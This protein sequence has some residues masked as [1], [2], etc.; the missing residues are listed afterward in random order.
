MKKTKSVYT[1][2]QGVG[3]AAGFGIATVTP[4]VAC[5]LFTVWLNGHYDI[6]EWVVVLGIVCGLISSGCGA[7]RQ[8]K[9]YLATEKRRDA[10]NNAD[11]TPCM[12]KRDPNEEW[13]IESHEKNER[14]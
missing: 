9:A 4:L 11:R 14:K 5:V 10:K 8:V 2:L 6:G 13:H 1:L 3:D 12:P 7:Y